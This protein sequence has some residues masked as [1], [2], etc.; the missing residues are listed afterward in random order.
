MEEEP[1]SPAKHQSA[2]GTLDPRIGLSFVTVKRAST[3]VL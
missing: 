3:L 2:A 1:L